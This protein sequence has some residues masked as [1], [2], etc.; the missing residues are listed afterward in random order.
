MRLTVQVFVRN[1]ESVI[2]QQN[3]G[4]SIKPRISMITLGVKDIEKSVKF[5]NKGLGFPKMD[6]QP[7]VAFFYLNGSW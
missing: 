1:S 4:T 5:Y 3:R 6:S 2:L 7:E